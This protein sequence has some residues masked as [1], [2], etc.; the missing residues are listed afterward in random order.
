MQLG[1]ILSASMPNASG[2]RAKPVTGSA[3]G[4]RSA[5]EADDEALQKPR[6]PGSAVSE[7]RSE[8][9]AD[10]PPADEG[11]AQAGERA[12]GDAGDADEGSED[13][14]RQPDGMMADEDVEHDEQP[15]ALGFV[16][17]RPTASKNSTDG[18]LASRRSA[19]Q[20][21]SSAALQ[22]RMGALPSGEKATAAEAGQFA[23][24]TAHGLAED[25]DAHA[26]LPLRTAQTPL[27][28]LQQTGSISR[29]SKPKVGSGVSTVTPNAAG[30]LGT[31]K[32]AEKMVLSE[33]ARVARPT[34][35][36]VA[37][38]NAIAADTFTS[39]AA[40][41]L[42]PDALVQLQRFSDDSEGR[43]AIAQRIV[44]QIAT[45]ISG[46]LQLSSQTRRAVPL[47]TQL[48]EAVRSLAQTALQITLD[49]VELGKVRIVF[50]RSDSGMQISFVM[51]RAETLDLMK[52]FSENLA[53]D[54]KEMGLT[55][56][57]F[58]FSG[59][60]HNGQAKGAQLLSEKA[61]SPIGEPDFL[62]IPPETSGPLHT[63]GVDIRL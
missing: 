54:L 28:G 4:F 39:A 60:Q 38:V 43:D 13:E 35:V 52:R 24:E 6:V 17:A 36:S 19:L 49:P 46:H 20:S 48:P 29:L 31:A 56:L 44:G 5:F 2:A 26:Q 58:S 34:E 40:P 61:R 1:E 10:K 57:S 22:M 37:A 9:C 27:M 25:E 55:N 45:E 32:S 63:H 14:P 8:A 12:S 51:E 16:E 41:H 15:M 23:T 42:M 59:H 47:L 7:D 3:D 33:L 53:R 30:D 50:N 21:T 18:Q 11:D 62:A